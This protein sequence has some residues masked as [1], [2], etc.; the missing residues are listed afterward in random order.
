MKDEEFVRHTAAT[1]SH[2]PPGGTRTCAGGARSDLVLFGEQS[3]WKPQPHYLHGIRNGV[4]EH[5]ST[6]ARPV[7]AMRTWALRLAV[8]HGPAGTRPAVATGAAAGRLW[9]ALAG[10]RFV[11]NVDL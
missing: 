5:R 3:C 9:S 7:V 1:H 8:S 11:L 2:R 4:E 10:E 6:G